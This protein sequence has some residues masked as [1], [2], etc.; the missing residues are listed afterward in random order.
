MW[1][2]KEGSGLHN[3]KF[4]GEFGQDGG[5]GIMTGV[6]GVLVGGLRVLE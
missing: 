6:H 2:V 4:V 5:K 1:W 3:G